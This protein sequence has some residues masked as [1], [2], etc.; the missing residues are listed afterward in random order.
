MTRQR[1]PEPHDAV[2]PRETTA[3]TPKAKP[4]VPRIAAHFH[5]RRASIQAVISFTTERGKQI[6]VEI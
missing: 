1:L 2:R 3:T 5:P 4:R 6:E